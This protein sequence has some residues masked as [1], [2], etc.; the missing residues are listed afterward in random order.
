VARALY[1][2]RQLALVLCTGTGYAPGLD[3]GALGNKFPQL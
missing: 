3:L 1:G 2:E